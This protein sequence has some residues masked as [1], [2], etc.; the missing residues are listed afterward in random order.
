MNAGAT[1]TNTW[2][3]DIGNTVSGAGTVTSVNGD[4]LINGTSGN[5]NNSIGGLVY[6]GSSVQASGI[7]NVT[8]NG[9]TGNGIAAL[10]GSRAVVIERGSLVHTNSGILTLN[11]VSSSTV[12]PTGAAGVQINGDYGDSTV[13]STTGAINII[14]SAVSGIGTGVVVNVPVVASKVGNGTTGNILI[15]SLNGSGILLAGA[16]R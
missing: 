15:R 14:G 3:V 2:A 6:N 11:G 4:I 1:T 8:I 7:G 9:T 10:Q 13:D 12:A 5:G 16:A